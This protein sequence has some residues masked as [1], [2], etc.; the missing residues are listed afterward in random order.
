MS[1]LIPL[2]VFAK[3]YVNINVYNSKTNAIELSAPDFDLYVYYSSFTNCYSES[4]GAAIKSL[5]RNCI[6]QKLCAFNCSSEVGSEP[7]GALLYIYH[8][9]VNNY[10]I[11]LDML[12][13]S[14][15][16]ESKKTYSTVTIYYGIMN[17]FYV[18][19]SKNTA[20]SCPLLYNRCHSSQ[21]SLGSFINGVSCWSI[22][23][24]FFSSYGSYTYYYVNII[25]NTCTSQDNALVRTY[26]SVTIYNSVFLNNIGNLLV[27]VISS[28]KILFNN[29]YFDEINSIGSGKISM[30]SLT[31]NSQTIHMNVISCIVTLKCTLV[32]NRIT[33]PLNRIGVII[34]Y[35]S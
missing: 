1:D 5:M 17:I 4:S 26:S 32:H 15:T 11:T 13:Y 22:N 9:D 2:S 34:L 7:G 10:N 12:S 16:P 3:I 18:N 6:I 35:L 31:D 28:S 30:G 27:A 21:R 8:Q 23:T 25:N 19:S 14:K 33:L 24:L 29:C 20:L